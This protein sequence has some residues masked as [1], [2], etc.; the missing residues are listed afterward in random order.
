M[1]KTKE[2]I[3]LERTPNGKS[4]EKVKNKGGAPVKLNRKLVE[5]ICNYLRMGVYL[6]DAFVMC[7]IDRGTAR[8]WLKKGHKSPRSLFGE[9]L[10]AVDKAMV[11]ATVRDLQVID[12]AA[13]GCDTEFLKHPP[14]SRDEHGRDISGQ[15]VFEETR[16]TS[17]PVIVRQGL[18]P[19][20]QAA[21]YRLAKRKPDQWGSLPQ[22]DEHD[23]GAT[24]E[25]A[26]TFKIE[27]V[28]TMHGKAK[29]E[30]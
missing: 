7:D 6:T 16:Y 4:F 8:L 9:L 26:N 3:E 17:K 19:S 27:F 29:K 21:A 12:K 25:D 5:K 14:G 1:T 11:E 2:D 13:N 22:D 10:R 23:L 30:D 20:W 15:L 18:T 24:N 28:E